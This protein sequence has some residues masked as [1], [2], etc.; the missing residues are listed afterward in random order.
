MDEHKQVA[1]LLTP[2]AAQRPD[3]L[4]I[5]YLLG[6]ALVRDNQINRG[7]VMKRKADGD[8]ERAIV[9]KLNAQTQAQQQVGGFGP[10]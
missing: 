2:L 8:R 7:Q 5:A 3:D 10:P 6:T 9:Q 4:A 1:G